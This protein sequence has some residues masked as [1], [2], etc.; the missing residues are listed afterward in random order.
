MLIS[1]KTL[2]MLNINFMKTQIFFLLV[3]EFEL[4]LVEVQSN[5]YSLK[6]LRIHSK[7]LEYTQ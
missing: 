5:K 2:S 6:A 7:H 1:A 4:V 3:F